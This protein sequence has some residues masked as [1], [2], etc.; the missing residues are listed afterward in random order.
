M[1][2]LAYDWLSLNNSGHL[3]MIFETGDM[4][5]LFPMSMCFNTA[6]QLYVGCSNSKGS[7]DN[8]KL[9][10]LNI[11]EHYIIIGICGCHPGQF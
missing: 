3:I 4:G 2:G 10:Q 1:D 9:F 8:A 6:G 7:S 5:I 11:S